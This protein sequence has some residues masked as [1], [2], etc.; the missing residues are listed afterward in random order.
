MLRL[1]ENKFIIFSLP[2]PFHILDSSV[3]DQGGQKWPRKISSF[4]VLYGGLGISK[5]QVFER[6]KILAVFFLQFL[7]IKTLDPYPDPDSLEMLDPNPY[8]DSDSMYP[9]P[10]TLFDS[11][12]F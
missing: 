7:V 9:D 3:V 10:A 11:K 6:K 2:C 4:E 1:T 8:P 12:S 5:L